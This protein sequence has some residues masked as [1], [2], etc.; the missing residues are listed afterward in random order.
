MK[1]LEK[2]VNC[3]PKY[4]IQAEYINDNTI[5]LHTI[6]FLCDSWLVILTEDGL[7]LKHINKSNTFHKL[8]YHTQK[9]YPYNKWRCILKTITSHNE[10]VIKIKRNFRQNNVERILNKYN[11]ER[12]KKLCNNKQNIYNY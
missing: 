2:I 4:K 11:K 8:T 6:D 1:C 7:E 9:I 5:R 12:E 10:Y 3:A